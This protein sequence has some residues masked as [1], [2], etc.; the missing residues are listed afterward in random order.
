MGKHK[1]FQADGEENITAAHHVLDL[2]FQESGGEAQLL[3][4]TRIL[5]GSQPGLLF[6]VLEQKNTAKRKR[7]MML[8]GMHMRVTHT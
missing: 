3:H 8:M 5:A 2:E 6:T 1:A 7:E 4:H